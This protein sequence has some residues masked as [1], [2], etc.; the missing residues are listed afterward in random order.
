MRGTDSTGV[1]SFSY[2]KGRGKWL[3]NK[4]AVDPYYFVAADGCKT[5]W[6]PADHDVRA[7]V[8]HNRHATVGKVTKKNSHPFRSDNILGVHNGTIGTS[9]LK[10]GD[11]FE[12]DSEALIQEI[13]D[14]GV[15]ETIARLGRKTNVAYA[16]VLFDRRDAKNRLHIIRNNERPLHYIYSGGTYYFASEAGHLKWNI[17]RGFVNQVNFPDP[18]AFRP[19]HLYTFD[20]SEKTDNFMTV[21]DCTPASPVY[22]SPSSRVYGGVGTSRKGCKR[23]DGRFHW[24][25]EWNEKENRPYTQKELEAFKNNPL[26]QKESHRGSSV[27][28]LPDHTKGTNSTLKGSRSGPTVTLSTSPQRP[29]IEDGQVRVRDGD[30]WRVITWARID[31][32]EEI[33]PKEDMPDDPLPAILGGTERDIPPF[34]LREPQKRTSSAKEYEERLKEAQDQ[35]GDDA[36]NPVDVD[37]WTDANGA[38]WDRQ[39]IEEAVKGG[40]AVTQSSWTFDEVVTSISHAIYGYPVLKGAIIDN[41]GYYS[42][43]SEDALDTPTG[44][45]MCGNR[46][47]SAR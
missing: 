15:E 23:S 40:C 35:L 4:E 44:Q 32:L 34:L 27:I 46:K 18:V 10:Y 36:G 37:L 6:E 25:D 33:D 3:W 43:I 20:L 21:K 16:L 12:T 8:G 22:T 14:F 19:Y 2:A 11:K 31:G 38:L 7:I 29:M 1:C 9:H 13:S 39:Q 5:T 26:A 47:S 17:E 30:T 45:T 42:Y 28:P 41:S 24:D